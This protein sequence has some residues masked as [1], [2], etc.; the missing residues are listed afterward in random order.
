MNLKR[1]SMFFKGKSTN[2]QEPMIWEKLLS[3]KRLGREE[4]HSD[5]SLFRSEWQKDFDRIIFS[6]GFRRMQDKTQVFPLTESDYPRTRLTHSLESAVVG[7]S[8]GIEVGDYIVKTYDL[9]MIN[10]FDF[11]SIVASACL[12]HDI[13]NPPFGHSGEDAI[14]DWFNGQGKRFLK[15]LDQKEKKDFLNFEGNAQGFRILTKLQRPKQEGGMQLTYTTLGAYTKYPRESLKNNSKKL[16]G[17]SSKKHGFFQDD[18]ETFKKIAK[19][20]RLKTK[21][22][23]SVW[24]RHPLAFLVEAADDIC[25]RIIDLE[26]GSLLKYIDFKSVLEHLAPLLG[27]EPKSEIIENKKITDQEK[28]EYLRAKAMNNLI[29]NIVQA[30][31]DNEKDIL[32]GEFD[33]PLV[34]QI[35]EKESLEK[36]NNFNRHNIYKLKEVVSIEMSGYEV[37]QRLLDLFVTAAFDLIQN[38]NDACAKS[39]KVAEYVFGYKDF[40]SLKGRSQYEALLKVTDHISGMSDSYAVS[41]FR[42]IAGLSLPNR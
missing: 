30:F 7:R 15:N 3:M 14:Q 29:K 37:L 22:N 38:G 39:K 13:G 19:E 18:G 24:Y 41:T 40:D 42:Q 27:T 28:V 11:G 2:S 9:K 31:K 16:T 21:K 26:D 23:N 10:A 20:L 8:L 32:S 1:L 12:A 36:L 6:T 34:D 4:K 17:V 35:I 5:Q 25:Y 33:E